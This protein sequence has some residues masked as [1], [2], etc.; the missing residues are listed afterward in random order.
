MTPATRCAPALSLL[1]LTLALT[2]ISATP[3]A[4]A[5]GPAWRGDSPRCRLVA[6]QALLDPRDPLANLRREEAANTLRGAFDGCPHDF[7]VLHYSLS[8]SDVDAT[9]HT[10]TG[11]TVITFVSLVNGLSSID[12]DLKAP[13][14]VTAVT[15]N[16]SPLPFTHPADVLT[17]SFPAPPNAGDTLAVDVAYTGTPWHEPGIGAFGGFWFSTAPLCAYSMGVG[18]NTDPPSCGRAWFPCYDRPCDKATMD[19]DVTMPLDR[20]AVSN[21]L[22]VSVDSTSTTHTWRWAHDYPTSTYLIAMS[23]APYR[24]LPD[25]VI[26]DPR[27]KVYFHLGYRSKALVSFQFVDLMMQAFEARYGP[28]PFDK[29]SYMTTLKGDMEH[30]TCVSHLLNLVDGTNTYDDILSHEMSHMWYGDCVTYGDWRDVWLSEGFATYSEAAFREYK[31]G[32]AAYHAYVTTQFLNAVLAAGS[33][34][35]HGV[36]DPPFKW[37]TIAYE[38]GASVLHMLRGVLD[39]DALFWQV[40]RDYL[41]AHKY[42]NAVTPD[43]IASASTTVGQDLHWFFDPWVYGTGHPVYQYG[44]SGHALGGGQWRVDVVVRQ[45]QATPTLFDLPVDFRVQTASGDQDFSSRIHLAEQTVSFV[46]PAQPTGLVLDPND[47]ILDEEVLAPTSADYGP[48]AA[49]KQAL[50]LETP[51][52]SPFRDLAE[53]RYYLPRGGRTEI[54]VHDVAGRRV[55]MLSAATEEAGTRSIWWDRRDDAGSR[56]AAGVYWVRLAAPDGTLA[57]KVVV[58]N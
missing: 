44:W 49:A 57:R 12:L 56:V 8:F 19:L 36:Y 28:Y 50:A 20:I 6:G 10:L 32:P 54:A 1:A 14:V 22:L 29:F 53:I 17:I 47:W 7:D 42:G 46:V 15:R 51:R 26:T 33:S 31:D 2:T 3:G 52:P 39:D 24:T 38:K 58:V 27:I 34:A 55:R 48:A 43:F 37:G 16:G 5:L 9:A 11:H 4:A 35:D 21:G 13:L 40:L 23:V 41:N 25:S 18:I 45:V 30:Q